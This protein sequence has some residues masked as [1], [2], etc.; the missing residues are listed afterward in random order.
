MTY[1]IVVFRS[2]VFGRLNR[3]DV[4]NFIRVA[5]ACA[6]ESE[7]L[8]YPPRVWRRFV[9]PNKRRRDNFPY[10][11]NNIQKYRHIFVTYNRLTINK[12]VIIYLQLHDY[13]I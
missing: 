10:F 11:Y 1:T 4:A 9:H 12:I 6:T 3:T 2:A 5:V 8:L 7:G 13:Q